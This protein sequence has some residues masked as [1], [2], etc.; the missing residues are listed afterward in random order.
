MHH[1]VSY[2]GYP[3]EVLQEI[4]SGTELFFPGLL[5]ELDPEPLGKDFEE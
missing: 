4:R 1:L 2:L 3:S 5:T